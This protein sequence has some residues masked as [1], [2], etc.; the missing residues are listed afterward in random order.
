M[1]CLFFHSM[2]GLRA[3]EAD[4]KESKR[5]ATLEGQ[6][7]KGKFGRA[8][9]TGDDE[10]GWGHSGTGS[11]LYTRGRGHIF[12]IRALGQ[13]FHNLPPLASAQQVCTWCCT[14]CCGGREWS[15]VLH[16][17]PRVR[18]VCVGCLAPVLV[19]CAVLV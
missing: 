10:A 17:V 18:V 8:G 9:Q 16:R 14:G 3:W 13:I 15:G 19:T 5:W 2:R 11:H 12:S 4:G 1:P 6:I 7:R